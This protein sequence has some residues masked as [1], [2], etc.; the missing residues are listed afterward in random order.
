MQTFVENKFVLMRVFVQ[1]TWMKMFADVRGPLQLQAI[2]QAINSDVAR[3]LKNIPIGKV[4]Q[5]S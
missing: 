5:L 2:D 1:T 3:A 4:D